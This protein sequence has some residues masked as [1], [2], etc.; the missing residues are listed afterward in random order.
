MLDLKEVTKLALSASILMLVIGLG[1]RATF[2]DATSFFRHLFHSPY[3]LLRAVFTMNLVVPVVAALLAKVFALP[4]PVKVAMVAMSIS[5]VPPVLPGKQIKFGGRDTFVYGLL[6]AVSL[7]AILSVPLSVE[8]LGRLFHRDLHM[9]FATM[10]QLMAKTILAP[11]AVGMAIRYFAPDLAVRTGH[12]VIR[13]GNVL[14]IIAVLPVLIASLPGMWSLIG[15]GT[16]LVFLVVISVAILAGQWIGGPDE[17][18][19]TALGIVSPLRHPGVA[20]AIST[21]NFTEEKLA[22][23]AIL[24]Y[25]LL[26]VILTTVYGKLRVR[27]LSRRSP[28]AMAAHTS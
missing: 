5:P 23:A 13:V 25:F 8:L 27:N 17:H 20:L 19:R 10:A 24:L 4:L 1:M 26:A 22:P 15:D 18:D 11:V 28:S 3:S 16:I 12:W 14:L 6:V 2:A 7:V 21:I 9:S